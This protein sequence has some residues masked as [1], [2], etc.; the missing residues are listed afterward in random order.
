[1]NPN[2]LLFWCIGAGIGY[3]IDAGHGALIGFLVTGGF[4]LL[5]T[6]I[7]GSME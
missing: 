7:D 2:A 6:I 5:V 4:S 3:L 1:M